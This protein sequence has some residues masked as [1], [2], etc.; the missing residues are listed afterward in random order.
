[1]KIQISFNYKDKDYKYTIDEDDVD[2]T[3]YD[4]IW[5]W[6]VGEN[7]NE[8]VYPLKDGDDE[9]N[10]EITADKKFI[11]NADGE[12]CEMICGDGLYVNVYENV[13][14]DEYCDQIFD[15]NIEILYA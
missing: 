14:T 15:W 6:W 2:M 12:L 8:V 13:D 3:H 10:F 5:D 1:M 9:L 7:D 4:E 11:T